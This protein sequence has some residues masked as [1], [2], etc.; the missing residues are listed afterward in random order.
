MMEHI[1]KHKLIWTTVL[2]ITFGAEKAMAFPLPTFDLK[3]IATSIRDAAYQI[4]EIKQ[5]VDSNLK[6]IKEI[7]NGG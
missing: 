2:M 1:N 4:M 7:V 6:I 3:R 5:E